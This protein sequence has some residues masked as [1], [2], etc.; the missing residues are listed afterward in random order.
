MAAFLEPAVQ[1]ELRGSF[2]GGRGGLGDAEVALAIVLCF[3]VI[4]ASVFL[5]ARGVCRLLCQHVFDVVTE[6]KY[7]ILIC[8]KPME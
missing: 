3:G 4:S 8:C 1:R 5:W 2:K 7:M 6:L